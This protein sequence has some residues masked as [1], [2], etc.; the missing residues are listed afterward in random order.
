MLDAATSVAGMSFEQLFLATIYEVINMRTCPGN[1]L[2]WRSCGIGDHDVSAKTG[3]AL[4]EKGKTLKG[5][6]WLLCCAGCILMMLCCC[7]AY[8]SGNVVISEVYYDPAG[9]ESG[10]EFI[11]LYNPTSASIDISGFVIATESSMT[12]VIVGPGVVLGAGEYYLVAD[13]GWSTLK[14]NLAWPAANLEDTLTMAGDDSGIALFDSLGNRVDAVGWGQSAAI[15]DG[16][17]EGLPASDAAEGKSLAR[18]LDTG[19]NLADFEESDPTPGIGVLSADGQSADG[20]DNDSSLMPGQ[21]VM[22]VNV[23][24]KEIN[25]TNITLDDD[26]DTSF[27]FQVLPIPGSNRTVYVNATVSTNYYDPADLNV[28]LRLGGT[29]VQMRLIGN[30]SESAQ[31]SAGIMQPFYALP[32]SYNFSV[33]ASAEETIA[34]SDASFE[35]LAMVSFSVDASYLSFGDLLPGSEAYLFGDSLMQTSDRPTIRNIGNVGLDFGVGATSFSTGSDAFSVGNLSYSFCD[36][37]I[38]GVKGPVSSSLVP[39]GIRLDAGD[40]LGLSFRLKVP[41]HVP[42]G[43]YMSTLSIIALGA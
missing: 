32:G 15:A 31:F 33:I 7:V 25:I 21:M 23:L 1:G 43:E 28:T 38:S 11:E 8:A 39:A 17:Y 9:S 40:A 22:L 10:G 19:S 20:G 29:A 34:V 13:T 41:D 24:S 26:D 14:D 42:S 35:Y 2:V 4:D 36:D 16:L 37:F 12:D 30:S 6:F 3:S 5:G 18:V 27:G